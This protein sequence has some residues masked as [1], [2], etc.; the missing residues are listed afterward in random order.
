MQHEAATSALLPLLTLVKDVCADRPELTMPL[1]NDMSVIRRMVET[2]G[3]PVLLEDLPALG[4]AFDK[5]LSSGWF[6][7]P[8]GLG[9][10]KNKNL[11]FSCLI[12]E[13]FDTTGKLRGIADPNTVLYVRQLCYMY[14]K[15]N[16]ACPPENVRKTVEEF[17]S[18]DQTLRP[19]SGLWS[20]PS[21]FRSGDLRNAS[22]QDVIDPFAGEDFYQ[23]RDLMILFQRVCDMV[24][25]TMDQITWDSLIP[26]HGPGA[27][28]DLK[29]DKSKFDFPNW[30]EK[31]QAGFPI[32]IFGSA[33]GD[34]REA[35]RDST[36][37]IGEVPGRLLAVPKTYSKP[38]LITAE[39]TANQFC[40]Q[41]LLKYLRGSLPRVLRRSINFL[42]QEP[43][44][45]AALEASSGNGCATVDLSSA[46]DLLSCWTVERAFRTN[47]E[48]LFM[49]ACVRTRYIVD[50]TGSECFKYL[51][52]RKFAGQGSAVTFPTQSII[53]ALIA[54]TGV[55]AAK[56]GVRKA[57]HG[58]LTLREISRA[59][60]KV[61]VFG[62]DIV[63]PE[64]FSLWYLGIIMQNLQLKVNLVKTHHQGPFR[65]SCGMDAYDG[66]EV[67]PVYLSDLSP[68]E[69]A[70]S[71]QSWVDV[72]NRF[73]R[74]GYWHLA[75]WMTTCLPENLRS[76]LVVSARAD[77]YA[78]GLHTYSS[79]YR[80]NLR[81]R[82]NFHLHRDEVKSLVP[83]SINKRVQVGSD[84]N[85]LQ[86]FLECAP[87]PDS[88]RW[89]SLASWSHGHVV[90]KS[91]KL[92][93]DWVALM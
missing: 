25:S 93:R 54:I 79:G 69:T 56:R 44:K 84:N 89:P 23:H 82:W 34:L 9:T 83:I 1:T 24:I 43:S 31:L 76:V 27:V 26:R 7:E 29:K 21:S 17:V 57:A 71:I 13:C 86:Y 67:T 39:P 5:G 32:E 47:P 46:S 6:T 3:L 14:K 75:Q 63:I 91:L 37:G 59:A 42:N 78:V 49:L 30:P 72:S 60:G 61:R 10:L 40:Q 81:V 15:L 28:A 36:I 45:K 16:V 85:L 70:D 20:D 48:L 58:R 88:F 65:E 8:P 51:L 2:R 12:L 68:S 19:P 33:W 50:A 74:A 53:Y 77:E 11:R 55:I 87:S 80:T 22:F 62:D 92:K 90:G 52:L 18:L 38:R 64:G 73:N 4:K 41:A 66:F 35:H